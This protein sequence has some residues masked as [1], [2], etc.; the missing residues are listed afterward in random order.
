MK[1]LL[2]PL[3]AFALIAA[4]VRA[5][6]IQEVESRGGI[7]AWLIEDHKLPLVAMSF[8]FRGGVEQDPPAK[9]GL[10][11]LTMSL[12]TE[13][14]GPYDAAA[15]Q[16]ELAGHSI[17]L[18]FGAG[19]DALEGRLKMLSADKDRGFELLHLALSKPHFDPE[20]LDRLKSIQLA[21]LK[22]QLGSPDWQARYALFRHIFGNHPYGE[23][24]LGS[25]KTLSGLT[26]EDV[27]DFAADHLARGNLVIA[28]AGDMTPHELAVTLD[29]VFGDLP[30]RVRQHGIG[31]VEW[32]R[33][34]RTILVPREGT[35]TELLFALPGPKRDDSGW[36][37]AEIANYILGGGG[38]SSRLMQDVRESR[39][40]TYG[41][42]TTLVPMEHGGIIIGEASTDNPKTGEAWSTAL[43][44]M[45]RFY[46]DGVT[47]KDIAGAK[48]YLTGS[49]PL[50]MTS[51]DQIAA[52]LVQIQLDRLGIDYLERRNKLIRNVT[53]DDVSDAI[54]RWFNPNKLSLG[55]AGSPQGVMPDVTQPAVR[56]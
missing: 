21:A 38:F 55:M 22:G 17:S 10:A 16:Q 29:R 54:H 47:D 1:R 40:L 50:L 51:T 44:T 49:L 52:L 33:D 20:D 37:A 42:T 2:L 30:L 35:Q 45:R 4:P 19:R 12:L 28:V 39:G 14:A 41:I 31:E 9:Q 18:G 34:T 8:A 5:A 24:R 15:F 27:R 7:K 23:R 43:A 11:Q 13:G 48:D 36:Y 32:P 25:I 3:L 53:A 6:E 56:N 26:R 46:D